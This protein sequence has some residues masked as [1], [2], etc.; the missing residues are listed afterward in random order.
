MGSTDWPLPRS[1]LGGRVF[2]ESFFSRCW[3]SGLTVVGGPDWLDL[4]VIG[5]VSFFQKGLFFGGLATYSLWW[6]NRSVFT[7]QTR[8]PNW[9]V[10]SAFSSS[11]FLLVWISLNPVWPDLEWANWPDMAITN[12]LCSNNYYKSYHYTV[13]WTDRPF[14]CGLTGLTAFCTNSP[15]TT[16]FCGWVYKYPLW[17]VVE[18]VLVS[19]SFP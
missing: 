17:P 18:K 4:W 6:T 8:T 10:R 11:M 12:R 13:V 7:G 2:P 3:L 14:A 15:P 1:N 9:P 19:L 16:S 5:V